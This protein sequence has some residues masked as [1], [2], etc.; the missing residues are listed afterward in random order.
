MFRENTVFLEI[1]FFPSLYVG[2]TFVLEKATSKGILIWGKI[3]LRSFLFF[4]GLR[5]NFYFSEIF[6]WAKLCFKGKI[7]IGGDLWYEKCWFK[8]N[9]EGPGFCTGGSSCCWD[10]CHSHNQLC[11]HWLKQVSFYYNFFRVF[12]SF[13]LAVKCYAGEILYETRLNWREDWQGKRGG[14]LG[15]TTFWGGWDIAWGDILILFLSKH[16]LPGGVLHFRGGSHRLSEF[17]D[18]LRFMDV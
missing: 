8:Q 17:F 12:L 15:E 18:V 9:C 6:V 11:L 3:A 13:V 2:D 7:L 14:W 1:S 4:I 16:V 10:A 5:W